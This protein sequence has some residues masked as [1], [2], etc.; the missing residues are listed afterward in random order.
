MLSYVRAAR[1]PIY[2][3]GIGM[4]SI[5]SGKDQ[6]SRRRDRR[7]LVLHPEHR[8]AEADVCGTGEGAPLAVPDRLLHRVRK[9]GYRVPDGGG[10]DGPAGRARSDD[11][12]VHPL[13]C[14]ICANCA[15]HAAVP[16]ARRNRASSNFQGSL[17]G[18]TFKDRCSQFGPTLNPLSSLAPRIRAPKVW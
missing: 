16:I 9:E 7:C 15:I 10:E 18:R 6:G 3:I 5:G 14:A 12:R 8:P 17:C 4:S 1:V 11:S 2:F 13:I